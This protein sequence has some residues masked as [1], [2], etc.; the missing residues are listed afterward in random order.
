MYMDIA[1]ESFFPSS[2]YDAA[3]AWA[4]IR[5]RTTEVRRRRHTKNRL[6]YT[7][8]VNQTPRAI[9][10]NNYIIVVAAKIHKVLSLSD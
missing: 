2:A 8:L 1:K 3:A 4:Y 5:I 9:C 7:L 6:V 10:S